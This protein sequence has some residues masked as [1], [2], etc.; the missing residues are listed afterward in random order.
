M[1]ALVIEPTKTP[2]VREVTTVEEMRAILGGPLEFLPFSDTA[3]IYINELANLQR[4]MPAPNALGTSVYK[5][6]GCGGLHPDDAIRGP[7]IILGILNE[8]GEYDG[9]EHDVP[10]DLVDTIM[11]N[12]SR[13]M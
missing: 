11:N 3:G 10:Q 9:D 5:R 7:M 4:P 12:L 1:K 6:M 13:F 8:V 2:E